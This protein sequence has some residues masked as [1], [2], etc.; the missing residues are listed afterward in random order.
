MDLYIIEF[1][2]CAMFNVFCLHV[3]R[4]E[5]LA[6]PWREEKPM[7]C[8]RL[9]SVHANDDCIMLFALTADPLFQKTLLHRASNCIVGLIISEDRRFVTTTDWSIVK[10]SSLF[11]Q[12]PRAMQRCRSW[13]HWILMNPRLWASLK[14]SEPRQVYKPR[15]T[16]WT[17]LATT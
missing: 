3:F 16:E 15:T 14:R 13:L 7:E 11:G 8:Q 12:Y 1:A 5:C 9:L 10:A 2:P 6:E 17:E 4:S